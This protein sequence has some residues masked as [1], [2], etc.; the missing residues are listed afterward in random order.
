MKYINKPIEYFKYILTKVE[1]SYLGRWGMENERKKLKWKH[2]RE[3]SVEFGG[4]N[5]E[6][7]KET[8]VVTKLT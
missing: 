6:Q 4:S 5:V 2:Q 3:G 8:G 7:A 1:L